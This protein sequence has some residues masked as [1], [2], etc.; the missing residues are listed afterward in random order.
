MGG[1]KDPQGP[2]FDFIFIIVLLNMHTHRYIAR[3]KCVRLL[4]LTPLEN[5][6]A[7]LG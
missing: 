4:A 5:Q 2:N 7:F 1:R 3:C 6:K